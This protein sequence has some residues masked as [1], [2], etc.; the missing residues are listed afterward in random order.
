[1]TVSVLTERDFIVTHGTAFYSQFPTEES[2]RSFLHDKMQT[3]IASVPKTKDPTVYIANEQIFVDTL[4]KHLYRD[5]GYLKFLR[6]FFAKK[7]S[8]DPNS[9]YKTFVKQGKGIKYTAARGGKKA[10][11]R[12]S[13]A[14]E[15]R[16]LINNLSYKEIATCAKD[17]PADILTWDAYNNI[18]NMKH[19]TRPAFIKNILDGDFDGESGQ[20]KLFDTL[21]KL[22][23][24]FCDRASV[25]NSKVYASI[26]NQYAPHAKSSLHLVGSWGTPT[27]ASASLT[28]LRHQVVIDVIPRQKEV[29]EYINSLLPNSIVTPRPK[30]DYYICPSEQ[31]HAR[32]G[33]RDM[34][35]DHFDIQMF[36]PVYFTTEMYNTVDGEAGEQ[37]VESFPTYSEWIEG[38][39]HETIKTAFHVMKPGSK[40]IIV[41]SDFEYRDPVTKKTYYIS[42]DML[43][44][45][46]HYFEHQETA[47]LILTTGSGFTNKALKEKRR[48]DRKDL[49]SEHVHVFTCPA[50]KD[51]SLMDK[52]WERGFFAQILKKTQEVTHE[53]NAAA[54]FAQGEEEVED[55]DSTLDPE[56]LDQPYVDDEDDEEELPDNTQEQ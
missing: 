10:Q 13:G 54:F 1:M 3:K 37:S 16:R 22:A 55:L 23:S 39:F 33:F 25:F 19:L 50:E 9:V 45:T 49:F 15:G 6:F 41:I 31:L 27:L 14:D 51:F 40:F 5:H 26:M 42:R 38:Y 48:E 2:C 35:R 18:L 4:I 44:I 34:Y 52:E 24:M 47:D 28:S 8:V 32:L 56:E 12:N 11:F 20:D 30:L 17:K 36:S 21:M 7:L 29:A 53:D 46:A 43:D